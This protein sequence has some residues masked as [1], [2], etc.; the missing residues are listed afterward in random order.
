MNSENVIDNCELKPTIGNRFI[1]GVLALSMC[2]VCIG[3]WASDLPATALEK[4]GSCPSGYSISGSYCKPSSNSRF[5]IEKIGSCPSGYSSSGNY[6]L[7]N[8][9]SSK[10]AMPK[11]GSCP[12]GY[13]TSG[14]YCLSVK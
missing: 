2:L 13:T 8:S 10:H 12:S 5:A 1:K 9:S 14:S 11:I 7:A 3:T 6:C 4:R